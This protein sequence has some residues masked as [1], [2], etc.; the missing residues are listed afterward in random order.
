MVVLTDG[1]TWSFYLPT[2]RG[3]YEDGRVLKLDLY[4]STPRVSRDALVHYLE[5]GRVASGEALEAAR[6][7]YKSRTNRDTARRQLPEAW[8]NL[9]RE[10]NEM[11]IRLL[12]DAV[13]SQTK[14]RPTDA[15]VLDFL[16]SRPIR[17]DSGHPLVPDR[18]VAPAESPSVS[19]AY[20]ANQKASK[21]GT[22]YR[23]AV[24]VA[25][26]RLEYKSLIGAMITVLTEL[27]HANHGFL[28]KFS[29]WPGIKRPKG[30]TVAKNAAEIFPRALHLRKL[31]G[32]LPNGWLVSKVFGATEIMRI[33]RIAEDVSGTPVTWD[34]PIE[35]WKSN[36]RF[37]RYS[38]TVETVKSK[39][40]TGGTRAIKRSGTVIIGS[41]RHGYT[42]R[43]EAIEI[44]LT[45]LHNADH[46]FLDKLA[47]HPNI[48]GRKRRFIARHVEEISL[49]HPIYAIELGTFRMVG[50]SAKIRLTTR[51]F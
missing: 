42:S 16:R 11:L 21:T 22:R 33:I 10:R 2:E 46:C 12:A 25:R 51:W 49:T 41:N 13:E 28:S 23:G 1:Q 48:R 31:V 36:P 18:E 9:V 43:S 4:E 20:E 39:Q 32:Q 37:E 40:S 19:P 35:A 17:V 34:P 24:I 3:S 27:E 14:V 30:K 45:E 15:D 44:V 50:C 7:E 47:K 8:S 5:Y 38:T 6:S 29:E 26:K